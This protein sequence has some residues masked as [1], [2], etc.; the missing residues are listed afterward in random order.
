MN[1]K[2]LRNKI[3]DLVKE[4]IAAKPKEQFVPGR[5]YINYA[6]RVYD[7]KELAMLVDR[8]SVV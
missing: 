4:Y 8:K 7:E 1:E 3:L 5:T 2:M 6:G